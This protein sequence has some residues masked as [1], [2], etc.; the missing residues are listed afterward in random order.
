MQSPAF[1]P[2][3]PSSL[4]P[5]A[6]IFF[7][8]LCPISEPSIASMRLHNSLIVHPATQSLLVCKIAERVCSALIVV[9]ECSL[10]VKFCW[11][12]KGISTGS[13]YLVFASLTLWVHPG[14]FSSSL[15][16]SR[17]L[18]CLNTQDMLVS[19]EGQRHLIFLS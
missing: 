4:F 16:S 15:V 11:Q 7:S 1:K 9:D 6:V 5:S 10:H 18:W 19:T 13:D 17:T 14:F 3:F 2:S 12:E 8:S